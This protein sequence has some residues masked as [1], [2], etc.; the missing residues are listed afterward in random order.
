MGSFVG[1]TSSP[2][3]FQWGLFSLGSFHWDYSNR[4]YFEL[5]NGKSWEFSIREIFEGVFKGVFE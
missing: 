3:S 1:V 5:V 4:G 2:E